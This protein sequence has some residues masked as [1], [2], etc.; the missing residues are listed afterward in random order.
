MEL[1]PV[2]W[3]EAWPWAKSVATGVEVKVGQ[4]GQFEFWADA[5]TRAV[6]D[7]RVQAQ[8]RASGVGGA[9]AGAGAGAGGPDHALNTKIRQVHL[10]SV[11]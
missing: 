11:P 10:A 3:L 9:G 4:F 6:A 5:W 7:A 1:E 8:V 2:Q